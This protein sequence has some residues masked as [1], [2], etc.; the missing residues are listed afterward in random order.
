MTSS[1]ISFSF[2]PATLT[3]CCFLHIKL[4]HAFKPLHL[5]FLLLEYPPPD[6]CLPAPSCYSSLSLNV[7]FPRETTPPSTTPPWKFTPTKPLFLFSHCSTFI[8]GFYPYLTLSLKFFLFTCS[9]STSFFLECNLYEKGNVVYLVHD[10]LS[11]VWFI[12]QA[13]CSINIC[14]ING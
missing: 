5:L 9:L 4:V 1:Q 2:T 10:I 6:L 13:M 12:T 7:I 14:W 3:F 11:T 8:H